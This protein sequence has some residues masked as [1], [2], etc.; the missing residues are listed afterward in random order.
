MDTNIENI[1]FYFSDIFNKIKTNILE[2]IV[3]LKFYFSDIFNKI[4]TKWP[5]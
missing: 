1:R 5:F 3:A 2:N 4:K